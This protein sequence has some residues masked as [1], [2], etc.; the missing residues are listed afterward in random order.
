MHRR[1]GQALMVAGTPDFIALLLVLF[2]I[3]NL[4]S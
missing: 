3:L 1:M 2:G 4:E